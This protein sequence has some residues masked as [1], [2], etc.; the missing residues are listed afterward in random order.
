MG[1][2][3]VEWSE[4][5]GMIT[6]LAARRGLITSLARGIQRESAAVSWWLAGGISAANCVAAYQA[7]GAADYATS[8]IN[9]ANPGTYNLENGTSY[10]T[11]NTTD[12]WV[13]DGTN[14]WLYANV[15]A[16]TTNQTWSMLF[17][18]SDGA[19]GTTVENFIGGWS[20]TNSELYF[21]PNY[22]NAGI[23]MAHETSAYKWG[24]YM[25]AGVAGMIGRSFYRDGSY[26]WGVGTGTGCVIT[27]PLTIGKIYPSYT[28]RF[29]LGKIQA[30]VAYNATLTAEQ[31]SALTTAMNAL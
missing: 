21:Q 14:K 25:T 22:K 17:R 10:P 18:F 23:F 4:V 5:S 16:D 1:I 8:K 20:D 26:V 19:T 15:Y 27:N 6:P 7:K 29:F 31:V 3:A 13:F 9:L 28:S 2:V 24:T 12:G 30:F 11:W